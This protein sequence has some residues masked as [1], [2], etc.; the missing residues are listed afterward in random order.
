MDNTFIMKNILIIA[1]L[2][3]FS[4]NA[5]AYRNITTPADSAEMIRRDGLTLTVICRDKN[6]DETTKKRLVAAFFSVYPLEIKRFNK[7]SAKEVV[8]NI[9]PSYKGVAETSNARVRFNP[10]WFRKHPED[11]DVV[12]HEL[13]HIVQN[14][15]NNE[16]P[17]WLTEG[18]ADYA[19]Y[20]FGINNVAAG[21]QLT[22]YKT[23]QNYTNAYRITAR[24]LVWVEKQKNKPDLVNKLDKA[25]RNNKYKP[26]L[27]QKLTGKT[28]DQLWAEYTADPLI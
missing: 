20:T 27:W 1:L 26:Q 18:I 28:V 16:V 10:E 12:T 17:G 4:L 2:I 23:G 9:D 14:Y 5:F 25:M 15:G 19:R 21:W 8:F 13:M 24:F 7:H 11:I 3:A 6:F 22:P